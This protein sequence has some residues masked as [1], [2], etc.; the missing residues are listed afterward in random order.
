MLELQQQHLVRSLQELHS[1]LLDHVPGPYMDSKNYSSVS[2]ILYASRVTC[3]DENS[4][5]EGLA[6]ATGSSLHSC[7]TEGRYSDRASSGARRSDDSDRELH[8]QCSDFTTSSESVRELPSVCMAQHRSTAVTAYQDTIAHRPAQH[9]SDRSF[10]EVSERAPHATGAHIPRSYQ[11]ALVVLSSGYTPSSTSLGEF[12][13]LTRACNIE[14]D[15]GLELTSWQCDD[16]SKPDTDL[17]MSWW[18]ES[19]GVVDHPRSA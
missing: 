14:L 10:V 17:S 9:S 12:N 19:D 6:R 16:P 5:E 3:S 18:A 15:L 11:D 4:M 8:E 7:A 1:L 13:S 2:D